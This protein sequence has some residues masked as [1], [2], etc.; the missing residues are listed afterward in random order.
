MSIEKAI[1]RLV[2]PNTYSTKKDAERVIEQVKSHIRK[3]AS[4]QVDEFLKE[5]GATKIDI[6]ELNYYGK[7]HLDEMIYGQG[8]IEQYNDGAFTLKVQDGA[9]FPFFINVMVHG[10]TVVGKG[11]R[12]YRWMILE[13]VDKFKNG[14]CRVL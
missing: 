8:F 10:N 12:R 14:R 13:L 7:D 9:G 3:E 6:H 2:D 4:T 1:H 5:A 11:S